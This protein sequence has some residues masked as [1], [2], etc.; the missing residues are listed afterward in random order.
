LITSRLQ[1]ALERLKGSGGPLCQTLGGNSQGF[2]W[3]C[4]SDYVHGAPSYVASNQKRRTRSSQRIKVQSVVSF[5]TQLHVTPFR[6]VQTS[7]A[8]WVSRHTRSAKK[9]RSITDQSCSHVHPLKRC[10][11]LPVLRVPL[12]TYTVNL[13]LQR[14][15]DFRRTPLVGKLTSNKIKLTIS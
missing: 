7:T 6:A 11:T 9:P 13:S 1:A 14:G 2:R 10:T 15:A 12:I 5:T 8:T 3:V 4:T